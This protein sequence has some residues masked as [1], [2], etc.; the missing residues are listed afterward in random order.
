MTSFS[1]RKQ[2]FGLTGWLALSFAASAL[3]A[4]ASVQ[5]RSFYGS[6]DQPGWAPPGSVF[7]PVWTTL[8]ALMGIAAWLCWRQG[9]WR[10]QRKPLTLFVVQLAVNALWSWLFF[11]WHLGA[12]SVADI[13]LLWVLIV[14]TLIGFWRAAP[15][16]GVLLLPYL[17]WV[18]FAGFLCYSVW[19]RNPQVLG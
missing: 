16:A 6:L 2:I 15:L 5:A 19:Q 12:L 9:G 1:T 4:I 8:Y 18:S 17:A 14:A 13:V 7:G 11:V 3:G 10:A